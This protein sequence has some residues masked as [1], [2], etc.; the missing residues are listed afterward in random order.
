[1][2]ETGSANTTTRTLIHCTILCC[3]LHAISDT[4][5]PDLN[6]ACMNNITSAESVFLLQ[7]VVIRTNLMS[8]L[9]MLN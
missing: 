8:M 2:Y 7:I 3:K 9:H 6:T 5:M 4:M 1:M